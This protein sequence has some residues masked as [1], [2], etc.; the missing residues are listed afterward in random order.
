MAVGS[1]RSSHS[2]ESQLR[3]QNL[4]NEPR[5]HVKSSVVASMWLSIA[6]FSTRA[7]SADS[8]EVNELAMTEVFRANW[9]RLLWLMS[10]NQLNYS[11][12]RLLLRP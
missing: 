6:R 8:C 5:V 3:K 9:E 10:C 7:S 11:E 2:L 4:S 1:E 12:Y